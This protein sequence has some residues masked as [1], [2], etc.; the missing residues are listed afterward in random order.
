MLEKIRKKNPLVGE[1][2]WDNRYRT[3]GNSGSGSISRNRDWKWEIIKKYCNDLNNIIDV[4]CGDLLF[5]EGKDCK[6]YLGIDISPFVIQKNK[7]LR[8]NWQFICDSADIQQDIKAKIVFCFDVLF[9][10]MDERVY[11]KILENLTYYSEDLIFVYTWKQNPF[12]DKKLIKNCF[13]S[14]VMHG[15]IIRAI[16]ILFVKKLTTD[17]YYQKYR[18]FLDYLYIFNKN[19][20]ILAGIETD[21]NISDVGAMYV[22]KKSRNKA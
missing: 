15:K 18:D 11:K 20:F 12:S 8:K 9:H 22:L 2:Y 17:F 10:I 14:Y 6:N 5:W 4:G 21:K 19:N 7:E 13:L 3:G 1:K 16:K